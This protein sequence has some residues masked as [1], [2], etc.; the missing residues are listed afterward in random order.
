MMLKKLCIYFMRMWVVINFGCIPA[1]YD[2]FPKK[3]RLSVSENQCS[4][5]KV[6]LN[7]PESI[8]SYIGYNTDGSICSI[9][10][11]KDNSCFSICEENHQ[12]CLK[13]WVKEVYNRS[14]CE[15][16]N[17]CLVC[18]KDYKIDLQLIESFM[19][20]CRKGDLKYIQNLQMPLEQLVTCSMLMKAYPLN[21]GIACNHFQVAQQLLQCNVLSNKILSLGSKESLPSLHSAV[22][23]NNLPLAELLLCKGA[24]PNQPSIPDLTMPLHLAVNNFVIGMVRLLLQYGADVNAESLYHLTPLRCAVMRAPAEMVRYLL[25]NKANVD[26]EDADSR[27]ALYNAMAR[28]DL[29]ILHVLILGKAN[30]NHRDRA[31]VLPLDYAAQLCHGSVGFK[32]PSKKVQ[33]STKFLSKSKGEKTSLSCNTPLAYAMRSMHASVVPESNVD[34]PGEMLTHLPILRKQVHNLLLDYG[35][36]TDGESFMIY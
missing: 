18:K 14:L 29:S 33:K 8:S 34:T 11:K 24:D 35:A 36:W 1:T 27:T 21:E 23:N 19:N 20:A 9:C 5:L 4:M 17:S 12:R 6:G 10:A 25:Q 7:E 13:C 22:R 3:K 30:V 31:R 28:A 26:Q 32:I 16:S 15:L 2:M